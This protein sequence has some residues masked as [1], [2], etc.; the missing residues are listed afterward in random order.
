MV[1]TSILFRQHGKAEMKKERRSAIGPSSF[2]KVRRGPNR[3]CEL[4]QDILGM[5]K[6]KITT[7]FTSYSILV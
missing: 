2:F 6:L 5:T 1:H 3:K 4:N 7:N